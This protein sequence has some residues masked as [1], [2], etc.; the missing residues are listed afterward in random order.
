MSKVKH[1]LTMSEEL[2]PIACLRGP[3]FLF[4]FYVFCFWACGCVMDGSYLSLMLLNK[5]EFGLVD[6]LGFVGPYPTSLNL[7]KTIEHVNIQ[8]LSTYV[9]TLHFIHHLTRH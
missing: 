3:F 4:I 7:Q 6:G 8:C 5:D 1:H 2:A 9:Y